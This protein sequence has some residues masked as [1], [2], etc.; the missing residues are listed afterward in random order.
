MLTGL[1]GGQGDDF[2][3]F[4]GGKSSVAD[5]NVEHLAG[6]GDRADETAFAKA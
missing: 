3:L 1:A 2:Q 6:R 5:R 4:I